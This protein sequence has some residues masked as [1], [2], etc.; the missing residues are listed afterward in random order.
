MKKKVPQDIN[1]DYLKRC[2]QS[3]PESRLNWLADAL[4]FAMESKKKVKK[5]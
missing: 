3:S 2:Q 4:E 1:L 5:N